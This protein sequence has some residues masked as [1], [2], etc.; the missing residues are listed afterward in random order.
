MQVCII[1]VDLKKTKP[2]ATLDDL[3]CIM[4]YD[5]SAPSAWTLDSVKNEVYLF[6]LC[7]G[8]TPHA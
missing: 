1:I 7:M 4:G 5:I 3:L 6:V 2:H 8:L